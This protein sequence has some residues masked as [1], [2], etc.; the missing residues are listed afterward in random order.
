MRFDEKG[1]GKYCGYEFVNLQLEGAAK[2]LFFATCNLGAQKETDYGEYYQ[3]GCTEP[4]LKTYKDFDFNNPSYLEDACKLKMGGM[5][6]MP[7][8]EELK[9]LIKQTKFSW[10]AID[11][12]NGTK[13]SKIVDGKERYVFFPAAGLYSSG[14]LNSKGSSGSV[15]SSTPLSSSYA[16][17]LYF[18]SGLPK[19]IY[20][21]SRYYGL[22]VRGVFK[23]FDI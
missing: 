3:S 8:M 14:S 16:Y 22:S 5:W 4:Y 11:G 13:F 7:T 6:R 20:S 18:N 17:L 2:N 21:G 19:S 10:V 1:R 15:W 9:A 23:L 12:V